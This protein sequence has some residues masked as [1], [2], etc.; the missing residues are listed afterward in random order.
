MRNS[1]PERYRIRREVLSR[2]ID[3]LNELHNQ[4]AADDPSRDQI[5]KQ[6]EALNIDYNVEE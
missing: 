1:N 3:Q 2:K 6:I 5:L 4:L